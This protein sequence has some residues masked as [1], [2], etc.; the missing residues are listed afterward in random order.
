MRKIINLFPSKIILAISL[1]GYQTRIQSN[2]KNSIQ[3]NDSY[4]SKIQGNSNNWLQSNSRKDIKNLM[5]HLLETA[6]DILCLI[7]KKTYKY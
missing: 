3:Q 6:E 7:K 1:R 4:N 2:D 5:V